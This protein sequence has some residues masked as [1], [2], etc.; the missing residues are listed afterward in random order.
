[1]KSQTRDDVQSDGSTRR[2]TCVASLPCGPD[3]LTG[4][5]GGVCR[6]G[7]REQFGPKHGDLGVV[8]G[9]VEGIV[10]MFGL[11]TAFAFKMTT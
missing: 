11:A 5:N 4:A 3:G 1:V 6:S 8:G 10:G 9:S 7:E 2:N